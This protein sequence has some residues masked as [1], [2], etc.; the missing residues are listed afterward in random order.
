[1]TKPLSM[2]SHNSFN[3]NANEAFAMYLTSKL[4]TCFIDSFTSKRKFQSIIHLLNES[5]HIY[6]ILD[7]EDKVHSTW[8]IWKSNLQSRWRTIGMKVKIET[9]RIVI[10]KNKNDEGQS[11][12]RTT[13]GIEEIILKGNCYYVGVGDIGEEGRSGRDVGQPCT[14]CVGREAKT[15]RG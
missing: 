4:I 6:W 9:W 5:E 2:V 12:W 15:L 13:P 14:D 8:V 10:V 11:Q 7:L 3:L 1:M